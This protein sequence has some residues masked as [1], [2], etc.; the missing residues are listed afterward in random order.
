MET[1]DWILVV[2]SVVIGQ[3]ERRQRRIDRRIDFARESLIGL[4]DSIENVMRLMYE[5]HAYR[6]GIE[7]V[8]SELS[9]EHS[10]AM[11]NVRRYSSRV[12][13]DRV[14]TDVLVVMDGVGAAM[15]Q[16]YA[17]AG[18]PHEAGATLSALEAPLN[19][20]NNRIGELLRSN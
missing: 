13:D 17:T 4:Q 2:A 14:R 1:S 7:P 5:A 3:L 8:P 12:D 15:R 16:H 20:I 9:R 10:I 11:G 6:Q 19:R 18:Y